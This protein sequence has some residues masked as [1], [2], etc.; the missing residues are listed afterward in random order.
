MINE[1]VTAPNQTMNQ[2]NNSYI[3]VS[4]VLVEN[5]FLSTIKGSVFIKTPHS[6]PTSL[7]CCV[8]NPQ[9]NI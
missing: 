5:F 9:Q 4:F 8:Y 6:P 3:K 1:S 2:K 7:I